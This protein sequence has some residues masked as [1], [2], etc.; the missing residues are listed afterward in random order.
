MKTI[1][2]TAMMI[3]GLAACAGNSG[4]EDKEKKPAAPQPQATE[5]ETEADTMESF[6]RSHLTGQIDGQAWT[7]ISG[8]ATAPDEEGKSY[9]TL[10]G[11]DIANP[12]EPVEVGA[13]AIVAKVELK[14]AR[15]QLSE[16]ETITL[17]V[18]DGEMAKSTDVK[19]GVL[20]IQ[21]VEDGVLHGA[22]M[23]LHDDKNRLEGSFKVAVCE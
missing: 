6:E 23:A 15:I 10:W 7:Q 1:L 9:L 3:L 8:R 11:V 4:D 14:P 12:C 18:Y 19:K 21:K 5:T 17:S 16:K 22:L 20:K 13:R 2:L